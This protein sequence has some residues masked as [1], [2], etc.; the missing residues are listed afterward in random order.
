MKMMM[1]KEKEK[2]KNK[3]KMMMMMMMMMT[4]TM[5]R[6]RRGGRRKQLFDVYRIFSRECNLTLRYRYC[7]RMCW[8]MWLE[9]CCS[10]H[11]RSLKMPFGSLATGNVCPYE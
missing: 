4:K 3:N 2:E 5:M 7:G 9:I 1:M 8:R 10:Y 11:A 6:R